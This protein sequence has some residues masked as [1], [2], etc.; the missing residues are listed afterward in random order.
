MTEQHSIGVISDT[1]IPHRLKEMPPRVYEL[2][3]GCEM[4]LHAGDLEDIHILEPLRRIAPVY[5]VRGNVHWQS[6]SGAHDQDLPPALTLPFHG[7]TLYMTH[8][9]INFARTMLDKVNHIRTNPTLSQINHII[10]QRLARIKPAEANIVVFGHTHKPCAER[11]AGTL[12]FNPGAVC[13]TTRPAVLRSIGR[14]DVCADGCIVPT[15]LI[16]D[17]PGG[18]RTCIP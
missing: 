5:A 8:G 17:E 15:W 6:S 9:H 14:L 1:H 12:Y 4:I 7:H 2:L 11:I 16:L 3:A 13:H 18:M 10:I